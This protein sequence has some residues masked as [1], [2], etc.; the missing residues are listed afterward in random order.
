LEFSN[1]IVKPLL[2][3]FEEWQSEDVPKDWKKAN[4]TN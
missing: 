1:V 2:I 4:V 3:I